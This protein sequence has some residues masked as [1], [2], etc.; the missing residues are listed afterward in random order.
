MHAELHAPVAFIYS[1]LLVFA[2]VAGSMIFVPLPGF[3]NASDQARIVLIFA[4]TI[5]LFPVWPAIP[6]N[7]SIIEFAGWI[8]IETGFGL[9]IGLLVGFLSDVMLLFGQ[10]C[11]LQA[12]FSFASTVDPSTQADSPVLSAIAQ[13]VASLLFVVLGLHRYVIQIFAQ[14]LQSQPPTR[15][16]LNPR[17]AEPILHAAGTIFST[18]LRLALPIVGVMGM[19]EIAL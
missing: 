16:I 10:M 17:W 12:G 8:A 2:R 13:S 4:I 9:G 6:P 5:C 15:L 1:F 19:V 14:S 7:P 18:G 11:G 3:R